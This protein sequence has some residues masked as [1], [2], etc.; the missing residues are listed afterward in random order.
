MADPIHVTASVRI[1]ADAIR[2]KAVRA[3]GAGGQNVNK[4]SSKVELRIDL[5][6]IE[7]LPEDALIRLRVAQRNRLDAEGLWMITSDRT[8]NQ[9]KNLDDAREKAV[10]AIREALVRPITRR[11][12]KPTKGSKERR[13]DSKKRASEVKR[14]RSGPLE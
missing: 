2:F 6:A 1:P 10:E 8:R 12:T 4:V 3:G 5:T 9:L 14:R 13:L 7:G 11:A